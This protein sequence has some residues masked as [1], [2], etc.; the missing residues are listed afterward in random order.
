MNKLLIPIDD[1]PSCRH[2]LQH[3]IQQAQAGEAME[4]HLLNVQRPFH[5]HVSQYFSHED[6]EEAHAE[7]SAQASS[8]ACAL[9]DAAGLAYSLHRAVGAQAEQ[10]AA[11]A[12]R[13]GCTGILMG[14]AR[15]SAVLRALESSVTSRVIELTHVPVTVIAGDSPSKAER[16]GLP[17]AISAG[18][19]LIAAESL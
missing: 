13:L 5:A 14:T 10:I 16:Y 6:L 17:A 7:A 9:L 1:S 12:D 19:A 3:V 2:A 15:K 4:L 18:L 11:H 8:A